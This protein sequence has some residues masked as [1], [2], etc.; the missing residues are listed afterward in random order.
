MPRVTCDELTF[1][2]RRALEA[3]GASPAMAAPAARAL[4][5]AEARGLAS[6]G[7]ARVAQ[8]AAHLRCGRVAGGAEPSVARAQGGAV[9][10][11]AA[12]GLAY[13]ACALAVAEAIARAREFGVALAGVTNSH[14]F[15]VAS[16]HLEPVAGAGMVGLAFGT[17]PAAMPDNATPRTS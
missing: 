12:D 1:L 6:H 4:V 10:I 5:A 2:A 15:G 9:L 3:A 14:H 13:A 11:D 8:Y 16:Y 17:A 7:V